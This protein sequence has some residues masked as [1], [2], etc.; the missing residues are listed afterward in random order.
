[1][2]SATRWNCCIIAEFVTSTGMPAT[3]QRE[4]KACDNDLYR[5]VGT[6]LRQRIPGLV[7]S[8]GASRNGREIAQAIAS[9]S[10]W[11][12]VSHAALSRDRG[13]ADFVT[14]QAAAEL[15]VVL[16]LERQGFLRYE[17][18]TD[19]MEVL[20][21]LEEYVANRVEKD[22]DI[23]AH[24][25]AGGA[26][27]G[28]S[29]AAEQL[30]VFRRAINSRGSLS[31]PQEVEWTQLER[32]YTLTKFAVEHLQ[33]SLANTGRLNITILFGFSPKLPFPLAYEEFRRAV[34]M[35]RSI[36]SGKGLNLTVSVG[37][38]VLPN[39]AHDLVTPLDVGA[40]RGKSVQSL[41]RL[42]AYACQP[43]S[44]VDLVRFGL[45]DT[46]YLLDDDGTVQPA[47]NAELGEFVLDKIGRHGGEVIS[48]PERIQRFVTTRT[49][50]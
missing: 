6:R 11:D 18:A 5:L 23:G 28:K 21:P 31:L 4:S 13:G 1:M 10:E 22:L 19:S 8:Y 42:V 45:E 40:N 17:P 7:L 20:R 46:P 29:S 9:G 25:T 38:A 44:E 43:D 26:D 48:S 34:K 30:A 37:A 50:P 35:A 49:T 32:S 36:G 14:I 12:R 3:R 33:P 39:K 2:P 24:S 15:M 47:S 16:D 41:E 27:Y